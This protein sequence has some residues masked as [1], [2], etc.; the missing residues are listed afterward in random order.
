MDSELAGLGFAFEPVR[1]ELAPVAAR[2]PARARRRSHEQLPAGGGGGGGGKG[3]ALALPDAASNVKVA[4][5]LKQRGPGPAYSSPRPPPQQQQ[6]IS[7]P[8]SVSSR[9]ANA[10]AAPVAGL[11]A[12]KLASLQ[13]RATAQAD[14]RADATA[15]A[16]LDRQQA[17]ERRAAAAP[18]PVH[19]PSTDEKKDAQQ[20]HDS[21]LLHG[22]ESRLAGCASRVLQEPPPE[23][24]LP[25]HVL[26]GLPVLAVPSQQ[27]GD[28][29]LGDV[30]A[31]DSRIAAYRPVA[32]SIPAT[33]AAEPEVATAPAAAA[34]EAAVES[35][36]AAAAASSDS[37]AA[38]GM[39]VEEPASGVSTQP[40]PET[41]EEALECLGLLPSAEQ[42]GAPGSSGCAPRP[43]S[44]PQWVRLRAVLVVAAAKEASA[45]AELAPL[46]RRLRQARMHLEFHQVRPWHRCLAGLL[47]AMVLYA[48]CCF[49]CRA[50]ML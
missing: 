35:K 17:L 39:A 36:P 24:E 42:Q 23:V 21:A 38:E 32:S 3:G 6:P 41:L 5:N 12:L 30:A 31:A 28:A 16:A 7:R 40:L 27:P 25:E 48:R 34:V 8:T 15:A 1:L 4:F 33:A 26:L 19:T 11:A 29:A 44:Q 50:P 10:A 18:A 37:T 49:T 14:G 22:L 43:P 46:V 20:E 47:S 9:A 45:A 13:R 2:Q